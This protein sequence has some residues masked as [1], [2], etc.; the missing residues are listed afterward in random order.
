[1]NRLLIIG[2][3]GFGREIYNLALNAKGYMVDFDIKG[4]LD[5]NETLLNDFRG[6]P[7]ILTSVEK[8][9]ICP[10]DVFICAIGNGQIKNKYVDIIKQKGGSFISL[11]HKS[12]MVGLNSYFG[13]G[14]IIA[15]NVTISC[16][17]K[18]G[19]F[20][21]LQPFVN[22]SHDCVIG[23]YCHLNS[24]VVMG[25]GSSIG[26]F[27]TAQASSVLLSGAKVANNTEIGACSAVV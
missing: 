22:I 21:T 8:Y 3:R 4:F 5:D 16:D 6:Y 20:V 12:S 25:G 19:D 17:V 2:A 23:N 1:M 24:F 26:D 15:Q 27:V 10:D 13:K 14:C 9:E 18:I 11:I 7:P